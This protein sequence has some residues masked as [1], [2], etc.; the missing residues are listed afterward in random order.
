[1][2]NIRKLRKLKLVERNRLWLTSDLP[3]S[4]KL[5][6]YPHIA[7]SYLSFGIS[8]SKKINYL[9][10]LFHYD[11]LAA[12][13]TL[14]GYPYEITNKIARNVEGSIETIL[15]IGGN[16]GQF[17]YTAHK[18]LDPKT[19][20]I[21]EPNP[22][23]YPML[24]QNIKRLKGVRAYNYGIGKTSDSK[25]FFEVGRSGVGSLIKE[26]AGNQEMVQEVDI[27]LVQDPSL[28]T[29]RS[30]YDLLKIDVEGYEYEVVKNITGITCR[31][32]FIELSG[33]DRAQTH[34]HSDLLKLIENK[35]GKF[36]IVHTTETSAGSA[37]FEV[38]LEIASSASA[39]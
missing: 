38:F 33:Q 10:R 32:V 11:N 1:M 36:N 24:R 15:D 2:E 35:F 21:F 4:L 31:Y 30:S 8:R 27:K 39:K 13:L 20:D 12:P 25:M 37:A 7:L 14:Q 29:K 16:I 9:G 18:L 22:K 34:T 23:V 26:N 17:S 19:I 5:S 28:I 3:F 6:Y